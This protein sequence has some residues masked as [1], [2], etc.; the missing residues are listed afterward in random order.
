LDLSNMSRVGG[1]RASKLA[2]GA[3]ETLLDARLEKLKLIRVLF[4]VVGHGKV[5]LETMALGG[6]GMTIAD[7]TRCGRSR[8]GSIGGL[9]GSELMDQ[10]INGGV[11]FF[12]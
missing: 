2:W 4:N 12:V 8:T 5:F 11:Q 1:T 9:F 7:G 3:L 10:K 6:V